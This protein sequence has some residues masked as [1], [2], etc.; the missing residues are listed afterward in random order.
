ME[1]CKDL[2]GSKHE[3]VRR[4]RIKEEW[5][6]PSKCRELEFEQSSNWGLISVTLAWVEIRVAFGMVSLKGLFSILWKKR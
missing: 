1:V 5:L 6:D 3:R 2:V 4:P